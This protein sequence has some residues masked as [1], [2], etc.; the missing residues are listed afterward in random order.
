[1]GTIELL[2]GMTTPLAMIVVG[3]VPA[4]FPAREMVDGW[5]IRAASVTPLL[6]QIFADVRNTPQIVFVSMNG[7]SV[8]VLLITMVLL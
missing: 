5:R 2:S 4:T 1:M 8:T 6:A 7:S 3:M